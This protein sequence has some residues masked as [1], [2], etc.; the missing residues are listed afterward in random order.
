MKCVVQCVLESNVKVDDQ[1]ISSIKKGFLIFSGYT[2]GDD[3][4]IVKKMAEKI[5]KLRVFMD[6][7]G[8][9]NLSLKDVNGEILSVSQFTLYAN[10]KKGNRP[11]FVD[12]MPGKDSIELYNY[13]NKCLK[14][15]GLEVKE[16]IFGADMK[17]NLINDGPFTL[18][19]DSEDL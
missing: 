4:L 12:A 15:E 1:L 7:N 18:V 16:G 2:F 14:E 5:S 10:V 8:K 17:V 3:Y 19:I 13:F 6:E 11:S 9:T